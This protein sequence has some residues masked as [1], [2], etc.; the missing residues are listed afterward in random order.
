MDH[1]WDVLVFCVVLAELVFFHELGHFL[2]AKACGVYCDRFSVGMPPRLF[3]IRI[4][5][6]DYCIGALPIGGYVKMAGQEDVPKT[7]EERQ[8]EFGHVPPERWLIN[9]PKWQRALVFAAGPIMNL[10]LGVILYGIVAAVG[11]EVPVSKVDNRIGMIEPGSPAENAPLY[12]IVG[13]SE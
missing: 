4:G 7:E 6:T 11:A 13:A 10:V 3:G 12:Q 5:E 9:R 1:F 8:E 2:A